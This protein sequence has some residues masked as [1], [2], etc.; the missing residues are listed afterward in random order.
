MEPSPAQ[1]LSISSYSTPQR[2]RPV[3]GDVHTP[4]RTAPS[5]Q[6]PTLSEDSGYGKEISPTDNYNQGKY[7]NQSCHW[8]DKGIIQAKEINH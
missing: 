7:L 2:M 3:V 6:S 1:S 4:H 8:D 5:S